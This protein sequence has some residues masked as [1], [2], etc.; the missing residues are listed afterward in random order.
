M[1]RLLELTLYLDINEL[2]DQP[3]TITG[4]ARY[5]PQSDE[6]ERATAERISAVANE[7]ERFIAAASTPSVR[8]DFKI[9]EIVSTEPRTTPGISL[10]KQERTPFSTLKGIS[11]KDQYIEQAISFT[12]GDGTV[13]QAGKIFIAALELAYTNLPKD[14]WGT[15]M[16]KQ[17]IDKLIMMHDG[18]EQ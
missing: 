4:I 9:E 5:V 12:K 11:P 1:T 8:K 3:T 16:A 13:T 2:S 17:E 7:A 10:F 18:S 15:A 14:L 6:E